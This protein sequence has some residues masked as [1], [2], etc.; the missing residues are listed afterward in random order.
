MPSPDDDDMASMYELALDLLAGAG[1]EH[2]EISNWAKPG[3]ACRHNLVYWTQGEYAGLGAGA[4][5]H[6]DAV[7]MWNEKAP[8]TYIERSPDA[9]A[10][11]ESLAPHARDDEWLQLRLRLVAGIGIHEV[12]R[13]TGRD[14]GPALYDLAAL[15]LVTDRADRVEP[16]RRGLF[17]QSEIA[18][19]LT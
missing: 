8:R 14:L 1:Y 3:R 12:A 10:G 11:Q 15:G 18:L 19:R 9:R 4:H 6:L 5:G 13:R 17:M 16:T 2:Y 7:R